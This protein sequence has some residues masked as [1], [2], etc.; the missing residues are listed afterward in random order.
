MKETLNAIKILNVRRTSLV[1]IIADLLDERVSSTNKRKEDIDAD[2][3][4]YQIKLEGVNKDIPMLVELVN[5]TPS[6]KP[7]TDVAEL[8]KGN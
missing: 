6:T 2:V 1:I 5:A 4:G 8:L 7:V 3:L